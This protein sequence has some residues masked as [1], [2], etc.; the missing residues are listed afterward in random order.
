[1]SA[2]YRDD[3]FAVLTI[4]LHKKVGYGFRVGYGHIIPDPGPQ[5]CSKLRWET[6]CGVGSSAEEKCG[7]HKN[8]I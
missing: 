8:K 5:H 3:H 7:I 4:K 2:T 1:M 6:F